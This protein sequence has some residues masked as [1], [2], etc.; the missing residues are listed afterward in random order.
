MRVSARRKINAC[1]SSCEQTNTNGIIED[2]LTGTTD[3]T[4][5]L[6]SFE[7]SISTSSL[8]YLM[9]GILITGTILK[10]I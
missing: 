4:K 1:C 9:A 2:I 5:P 8:F 7:V 6:G 10:K 3:T